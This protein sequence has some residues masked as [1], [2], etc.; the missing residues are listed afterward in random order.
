MNLYFNAC[1]K[2]SGTVE[3]T[4]IDHEPELRCLRCGRCWLRPIDSKPARAQLSSHNRTTF[5]LK[6]EPYMRLFRNQNPIRRARTR[7]NITQDYAA[8]TIGVQRSRYSRW[9]RG[10]AN[11]P[12]QWTF[13]VCLVLQL[14]PSEIS[15][16]NEIEMRVSKWLAIHKERSSGLTV[17]QVANKYGVSCRTV[18]RVMDEAGDPR[19]LE[20]R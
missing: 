14:A 9:E 19:L 16:T 11:V 20:A 17:G 10:L 2:C 4:L 8:D 3:W 6:S 13:R 15:V 12:A 7:L 5:Y 1:K 18:H